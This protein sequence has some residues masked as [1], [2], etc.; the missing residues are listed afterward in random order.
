MSTI[1]KYC[2]L[3]ELAGFLGLDVSRVR[4]LKDKGLRLKKLSNGKYS[5]QAS[6]RAYVIYLKESSKQEISVAKIEF[7]QRALLNLPADLDGLATVR[8]EN[9]EATIAE[10]KA[11]EL[12]RQDEISIGKLAYKKDVNEALGRDLRELK[13]RCHKWLQECMKIGKLNPMER[14][15]RNNDFIEFF[16]Q[17]AQRPW[18]NS[19]PTE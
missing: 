6:V 7:E 5:F 10:M 9:A 8:K 2:T 13:S 14:E 16:N 4:Q 3:T 11:R 1:P 15:R 19:E 18:W 12:K 17:L